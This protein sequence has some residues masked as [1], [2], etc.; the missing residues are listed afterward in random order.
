LQEYFCMPYIPCLKN[1]KTLRLA[2]YILQEH[3][4][5]PYIACLK[6]GK[7]L[8]LT[9]YTLKEHYFVPY[10][11]CLKDGKTLKLTNY[12]LHIFFPN[13]SSL[14]APLVHKWNGKICGIKRRI[15]IETQSNT[16]LSSL[17][18]MAHSR[19]LDKSFDGVKDME[20]SQSKKRTSACLTIVE[21]GK[22]K[23]VAK[24]NS[25][26]WLGF[27]AMNALNASRGLQEIPHKSVTEL[28]KSGLSEKKP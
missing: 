11:A 13:M 6:N 27:K 1:C 26:L 25:H 5:V 14:Q 8:R 2:N 16:K 10:I 23:N 7:I 19:S 24:R 28:V 12:T 21:K 17:C 3:L 18:R 15:F 9:N 22:I 4:F 20:M